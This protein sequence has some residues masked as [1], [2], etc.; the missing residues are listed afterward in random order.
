MRRLP[1]SIARALAILGLL[2]VTVSTSYVAVSDDRGFPWLLAGLVLVGVCALGSWLGEKKRVIS[3]LTIAALPV[4]YL[5]GSETAHVR[6][7]WVLRRELPRYE[8]AARQC[9]ATHQEGPCRVPA[10]GSIDYRYAG[11]ERRSF[12]LRPSHH[13]VYVVYAPGPEGQELMQREWCVK[14]FQGD[15]YLVSPC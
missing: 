2:L 5:A 8:L 3:L 10:L 13:D 12:W 4:A 9:L 14:P 15:W 7:E 6:S 11:V 1:P